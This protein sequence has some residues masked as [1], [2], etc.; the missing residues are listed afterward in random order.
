[1]YV[2]QSDINIV[3]A[4]TRLIEL[5]A[6][7]GAE[8]LAPIV[9]DEILIRLLFSPSRHEIYGIA[10]ALVCTSRQLMIP[11]LRDRIIFG[12]ERL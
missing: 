10:F 6:Q 5:M 8:M 4:A 1:M 9:V 3:S 7:P 2:G 12:C 11:Y